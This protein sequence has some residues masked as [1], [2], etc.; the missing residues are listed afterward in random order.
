MVAHVVSA[1]AAVVRR[2]ILVSSVS[3]AL[4]AF[5]CADTMGGNGGEGGGGTGGTAGTGGSGPSGPLVVTADWLNQSLTLL[6]YD[7]LTDGSSTGEDSIVG[8]IDLSDFAPGPLELELTPDGNIAVVS[9]A[10]GF[11]DGTGFTNMIIGSPTVPPGGTLLVV[12]LTTGDAQSIETEDVPMGIAISPDGSTVYTANF[13]TTDAPG[14][15]LSIID[16]VTLE[17][18]EEITVGPGPEQVVLSPDGALGAVN[19][20]G[21][22]GIRVFETSDVAGTMTDVIFTGDDPSD[23]TFLDDSTRLLVT[24][25][26][27]LSVVLV[28]TSN[29]SM[30]LVLDTRLPTTGTPYGITYVPSRSLSLAPTSP[31][32]PNLS[33]QW[34]TIMI[35][36][37]AIT[38][39]RADPLAGGP[40]VLD[41]AV[42]AT[43]DFA[44]IAHV[45]DQQLS[46]VDLETGTVR[47]VSWLTDFGP[48]YVAVQR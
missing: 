10:P 5:G 3:L 13:G 37:D 40:F 17:V 14:D 35:E 19:V 43:G 11:F 16:L 45:A 28:D 1:A 34:A 48:T 44:F 6:D 20:A 32:S 46:I 7:R 4:L 30:P 47:G 23:L 8:T 15:S 27:S 9:V 42:D 39:S 22:D 24:N 33:A 2:S 21:Q 38:L 18:V 26:Q 36:N 25:S 41:A 29:P 31:L 12:D